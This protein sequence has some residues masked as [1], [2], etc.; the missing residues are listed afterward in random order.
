M[1]PCSVTQEYVNMLN[2]H[3]QSRIFYHNILDQDWCKSDT[4]VAACVESSATAGTPQL[5]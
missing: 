1:F 3:T 2:S 4:L 5:F